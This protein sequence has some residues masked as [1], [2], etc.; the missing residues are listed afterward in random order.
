MVIHLQYDTRLAI[1]VFF[2]QEKRMNFLLENIASYDDTR[3]Q[4]SDIRL[5]DTPFTVSVSY[6]IC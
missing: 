2:E 1:E 5:R 3:I 6:F 4:S